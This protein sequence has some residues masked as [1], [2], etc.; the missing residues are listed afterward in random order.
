[1]ERACTAVLDA[2]FIIHISEMERPPAH[3][4]AILDDILSAL[5]LRAVVHPLVYDKEINRD[6]PTVAALI[7]EN[8]VC[9]LAFDRDVFRGDAEKEAYY[10][11]LVPELY[12]RLTG[13]S[14]PVDADVLTFWKRQS[15]LGEI[16]SVA[17]CLICQFGLFLSDD[18]DSKALKQIV[19]HQTL[20]QINVYNRQE[21]LK[22]YVDAGEPALS[23]ADRRAFAHQ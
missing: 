6:N 3:A 5:D 9:P 18:G 1:M 16:H 13:D 8:V 17:M 2:D 10:R 20:G 11:Y 12:R 4:A 22:Q 15:S 21:I 19:E 14:L 7:A 23:R